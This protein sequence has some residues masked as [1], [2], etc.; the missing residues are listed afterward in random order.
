MLNVL[1]HILLSNHIKAGLHLKE[2]MRNEFVTAIELRDSDNKLVGSWLAADSTVEN[3]YKA[4]TEYVET[5]KA[6]VFAHDLEGAAVQ[7]LDL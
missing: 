7:F 2:V 5:R 6:V 3:V 4:A 1:D